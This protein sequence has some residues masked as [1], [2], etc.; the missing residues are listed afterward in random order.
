MRNGDIQ[1]LAVSFIRKMCEKENRPIKSMTTNAIMLLNS[2]HWPGNVRQLENVV[3]RAVIL[4]EGEM[5][6]EHDFPQ[7]AADIDRMANENK[8]HNRRIDDLKKTLEIPKEF[9]NTAIYDENAD[10]FPIDHIEQMMIRYAY[11]R[12]EGRMTEIARRLKIGRSTL[13]RKV[14]E[15]GLLDQEK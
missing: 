12:Y 5:I 8:K 2:Y 1:T 4:S 13:Y 6:T 9:H 15:L 11:L 10:V 3:L 7:I 14:E